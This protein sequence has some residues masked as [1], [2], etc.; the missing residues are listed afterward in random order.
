MKK[1]IAIVVVL[2]VVL[3]GVGAGA[4]VLLRPKTPEQ[5]LV[6]NWYDEKQDVTITFK[7]DKTLE[8]I[9]EDSDGDSR[10]GSW[11]M[12]GKQVKIDATSGPKGYGE[13]PEGE[14]T[15]IYFEFPVYD[16]NMKFFINSGNFKKQ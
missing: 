8:V 4:Y 1:V 15:S 16:Q 6:G 5:Q 2:L 11:R 12:A 7:A 3:G 10:T 13:L 9:K 14:I